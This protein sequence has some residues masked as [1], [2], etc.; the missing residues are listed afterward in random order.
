MHAGQDVLVGRH[1]ERRGRV[2][3]AFG[4]D[5]DGHAGLEQQRGVRMSEVVKP[6]LGQSRGADLALEGVGDQLRMREGAVG[7]GKDVG[8]T[9]VGVERWV[10]GGSLRLPIPQHLNVVESRSMQRRELRVLPRDSWSS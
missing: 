2:A 6:D 9:I 10:L 8:V 5:L 3:E 1:R 7:L 4:H